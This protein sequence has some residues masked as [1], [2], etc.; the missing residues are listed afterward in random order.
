MAS[1]PGIVQCFSLSVQSQNQCAT[2]IVALVQEPNGSGQTK[3]YADVYAMMNRGAYD[4]D[5]MLS[6]ISATVRTYTDVTLHIAT[7]SSIN[8]G[9]GFDFSIPDGVLPNTEGLFHLGQ[10]NSQTFDY[11]SFAYDKT[12]IGDILTY[13]QFNSYFTGTKLTTSPVAMRSQNLSNQGRLIGNNHSIVFYD[14]DAVE[15]FL[16]ES[17]YLVNWTDDGS[18]S[19]DVKI[20]VE[21]KNPTSQ[22]LHSQGSVNSHVLYDVVP[23]SPAGLIPALQQSYPGYGIYAEFSAYNNVWDT[24]TM[25]NISTSLPSFSVNNSATKTTKTI[26]VPLSTFLKSASISS[27]PLFVNASFKPYS[28]QVTVPGS[29]SNTY[30]GYLYLPIQNSP[31]VPFYSKMSGTLDTTYS[32][33]II[34]YDDANIPSGHK[35]LL[36]A[37]NFYLYDSQPQKYNTRWMTSLTL[38]YD[39]LPQYSL[40]S[41]YLMARYSLDGGATWT[42]WAVQGDTFKRKRAVWQGPN[43]FPGGSNANSY[44]FLTD[45]N[46]DFVY[47]PMNTEVDIK[48]QYKLVNTSTELGGESTIKE[49]SYTEIPYEPPTASV[50]IDAIDYKHISAQISN[51]TGTNANASTSNKQLSTPLAYKNS[52]ASTAYSMYQTYP[53]G[54]NSRSNNYVDVITTVGASDYPS[55]TYYNSHINGRYGNAL[56]GG[57][58]IAAGVN[59]QLLDNWNT[60]AYGAY[61]KFPYIDPVWSDLEGVKCRPNSSDEMQVSTIMPPA[62]LLNWELTGAT[63]NNGAF[64]ATLFATL[65]TSY[66]TIYDDNYG[67][68]LYSSSYGFGPSRTATGTSGSYHPT[69]VTPEYTSDFHL[70]SHLETRYSLDNGTTWTNWELTGQTEGNGYTITSNIT[71]LPAG[72]HVIVQGRQYWREGSWYSPIDELEFDTPPLPPDIDYLQQTLIPMFASQRIQFGYEQTGV[73][74]L[75]G[76]TL[77]C[78]YRWSSNGGQTWNEDWTTFATNSDSGTFWVGQNAD[79][80]TPATLYLPFDTDVLFEFRAKKTTAD[81]VEMISDSATMTIHT[82]EFPETRLN[83]SFDP[84]NRENLTV[85][86]DWN[87]SGK[88]TGLVGWRWRMWLVIDNT[89]TGAANRIRV[90]GS[91]G[92]DAIPSGTTKVFPLN[93]DSGLVGDASSQNLFPNLQFTLGANFYRPGSSRTLP[94][95]ASYTGVTPRPILGLAIDENGNQKKITDIAMTDIN[96]SLSSNKLDLT[97]KRFHIP[98]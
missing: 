91:G 61:K 24:S 52:T 17:E 82:D 46:N 94:G 30:Y 22:T 50:T 1:L 51:T 75:D 36:R 13:Q 6:A 23:S 5:T 20:G 15:T 19:G 59:V 97:Y 76:S 93:V 78:Q 65:R 96:E 79:N 71:G 42:N 7:P 80:A 54:V 44:V 77:E 95:G 39:D 67:G 10:T 73:N 66:S 57:G 25:E 21:Y 33:S 86:F 18:I 69:T 16:T 64:I 40:A 89:K 84:L 27:T 55:G 92:S 2:F 62:K 47:F 49:Y 87:Y 11:T 31:A 34:H 29:S 4:N 58:F 43:G 41:T 81:N 98:E 60:P 63:P 14:F 8:G 45:E 9:Q 35:A 38:I 26:T 28:A 72:Q 53:S 32:P 85:T 56:V 90:T 83:V 37:P 68:N 70:I 12:V 3:I 48:L 74:L 88:L